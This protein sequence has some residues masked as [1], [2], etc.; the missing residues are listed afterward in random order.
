MG[1]TNEN[2]KVKTLLLDLKSGEEEKQL[3]AIK[4][5]KVSGNV[6]VLEPMI[7]ELIKTDS[8]KVEHE[9][10]EFLSS[11]KD[12]DAPEAMIK[13]LENEDFQ[14]VR[15]LL[16]NTIWN[17]GLDYKP[18]LKAIVNVAL[19][20]EMMEA[21]ECITILEN[22]NGPFTEEE[23]M[24]PLLSVQEYLSNTT[25]ETHKNEIIKEIAVFLAQINE[26]L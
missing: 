14:D 4:A 13:C 6:S 20:G 16:L 7:A 23:I 19:D 21:L 17:S 8:V 26:N 10:I 18:H 2:K 11:L 3:K 25:E 24:E 9:I 15:G 5:L 12:S 22:T 1:N